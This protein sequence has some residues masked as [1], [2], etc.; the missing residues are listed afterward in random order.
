MQG[1]CRSCNKTGNP[2]W[3]QINKQHLLFNM[4]IDVKNF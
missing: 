4:I 3:F 2:E 1:R